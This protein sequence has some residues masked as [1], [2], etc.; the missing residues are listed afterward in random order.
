MKRAN[1]AL[2]VNVKCY[3]PG[4]CYFKLVSS[5]AFFRNDRSFF[6]QNRLVSGQRRAEPG[7][8]WGGRSRLRFKQPPRPSARVLLR[9]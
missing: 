4:G 9:S 6:I 5:Y 3:F 8:A 7:G 1:S 2:Q